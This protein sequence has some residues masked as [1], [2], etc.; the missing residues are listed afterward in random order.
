[1]NSSAS[2]ASL[3]A[4]EPELVDGVHA[5]CVLSEQWEE[6][7][8]FVHYLAHIRDRLRQDLRLPPVMDDAVGPP[9]PSSSARVCAALSS[10]RAPDDTTLYHRLRRTGQD[11]LT[12]LLYATIR[13]LPPP[14]AEGTTV[15]VDGTGLAPGAISTFCVNRVRDRGEGLTWRHWLKWVVVVDLPHRLIWAQV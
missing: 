1:M 9:S 10:E 14:P 8:E 3:S 7:D 13:R 11:E 5:S 15:A 2:G 6:L 4:A 12:R